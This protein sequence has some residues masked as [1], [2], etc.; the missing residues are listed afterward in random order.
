M[1]KIFLLLWFV[2]LGLSKVQAYE[3]E[4]NG[5]YYDIVNGKAVVVSG[6]SV[7]YSGDVVIPE[8]VEFGGQHYVVDSIG[9]WAFNAC[10]GLM[11]VKL[12]EKLRVIGRLAFVDCYGLTSISF[13]AS[14]KV[15]GDGAFENCTGIENLELPQGLDSI[16]SSAFSGCKRLKDMHLPQEL[17]YIGMGA[18]GG[19]EELISVSF[20]RKLENI[21]YGAFDGCKSLTSVIFPEGL[22]TIGDY[23][24]ANCDKLDS[25][26]FPASLNT[27][28]WNAFCTH[29]SYDS[30]C[31]CE[32]IRYVDVKD[33]HTWVNS[34]CRYDT[35]DRVYLPKAQLY[36]D[37]TLLTEAVIPE[38]V[39]EI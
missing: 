32:H 4:K 14:L 5:I 27:I 20:P 1:K 2:L 10:S 12:P 17:K 37:G 7:M 11:S 33:L 39:E 21:A 31:C 34:D 19:C 18:F 23:A 28:N 9:E 3:F 13:P 6:G 24:F 26:S 29:W 35:Y 15:I 36:L 30:P 16:K 38:G 8:T 22:K 25:L